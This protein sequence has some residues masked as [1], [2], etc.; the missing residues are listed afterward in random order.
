MTC[1]YPPAELRALDEIHEK[2]RN[3]LEAVS[4]AHL[5]PN[6]YTHTLSEYSLY[7]VACLVVL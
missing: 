2:Q 6:L 5:K 1:T 3:L 7:L 4:L